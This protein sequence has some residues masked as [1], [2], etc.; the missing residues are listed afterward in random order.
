MSQIL[1]FASGFILH[2]WQFV[3]LHVLFLNGFDFTSLSFIDLPALSTVFIFSSDSFK[4]FWHSF[5]SSLFWDCVNKKN[6]LIS[7]FSIPCS[8]FIY[9]LLLSSPYFPELSSIHRA[10]SFPD[11]FYD[12]S[13]P[14]FC[15]VI[16]LNTLSLV[17]S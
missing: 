14:P 5:A 4:I 17:I 13:K 7:S 15:F 6:C 16:H 9:F 11:P 3:S 2:T 10:F 1:Q 12:L 8:F